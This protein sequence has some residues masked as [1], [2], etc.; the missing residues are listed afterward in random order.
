MRGIGTVYPAFEDQV[1]FYAV[2]FNEGLDILSEAQARS[3]HPG[4]VATPSPKM[5]SDFNV[6]RQSTKVAIDANGIIVYRAGYRQ[7]Y[8]AE[9]DSVLKE[10]T[11]AN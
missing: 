6:T 9:W 3:G 4:E 8:P 7:G 5:I 1:D 11:A 10:L 2:A